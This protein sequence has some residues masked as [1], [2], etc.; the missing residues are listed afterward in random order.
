M[1]IEFL[2]I[3]LETKKKKGLELSIEK[4]QQKKANRGKKSGKVYYYESPEKRVKM[5]VVS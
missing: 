2:T 3:D 4:T 1:F 5:Y